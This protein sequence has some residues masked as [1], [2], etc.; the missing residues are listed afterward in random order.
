M[1]FSDLE[2]ML[3]RVT[4]KPGYELAL[5][6][7]SY[8]FEPHTSTMICA[9]LVV[10]F[11]AVDTYDNRRHIPL[12]YRADLPMIAEM[13]E[14]PEEFFFN[15][16]ETQ[17]IGMEAHEAREWFKIDGKIKHDPHKLGRF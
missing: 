5:E 14:D 1:K 3:R 17:L 8:R 4:Y 7:D 9:T 12:E 2:R 15:W 16:L 6:D 11:T 13:A 10:R